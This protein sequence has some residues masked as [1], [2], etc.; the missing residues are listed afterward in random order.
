M[1][2]FHAVQSHQFIDGNFL[3]GHSAAGPGFSPT[4]GMERMSVQ[5]VIKPGGVFENPGANQR[6]LVFWYNTDTQPHY[7]VI[8]C[9]HLK[10]E[11]KQ[12][13]SKY[14]YSPAANFQAGVPSPLTGP[15]TID[16]TCAIHDGEAGQLTVN[17]DLGSVAGTVITLVPPAASGKG[18]VINI[19]PGGEFETVDVAQSDTLVWKNNDSQTHFPVPN[20]TGLRVEPEDVS[21]SL[22]PAPTYL[23]PMA[24][25]Y[26]CAMPGHESE[27]GTINVYGDFIVPATQ[28]TLSSATP[29]AAVAAATGGKSPYAIVQDGSLPY[30]TAVE[31]T[32]A[33]SSAG[34]SVVLNAVPTFLRKVN[35]QLNVTDALGNQIGITLQ[36]TLT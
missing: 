29:F 22:Q 14:P 3:E 26:G 6:D 30:I 8:G 11:P 19:G 31:T 24:I 33:G 13:T 28:L 7:P 1:R 4:E 35:Y 15:L 34:V 18:K 23:L 27:S 16:Y 12:D 20:C 21:N 25:V 5:I 9:S 2:D 17:A 32:P 10:V 36:I